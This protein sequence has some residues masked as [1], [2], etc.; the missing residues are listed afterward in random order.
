MITEENCGTEIDH[1][2]LAVGYGK[3][4]ENDYFLVKNSWGP[5]CGDNG[6]VKIGVAEGDGICG[7]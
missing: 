6:F 7:I 3:E 1:G 2:V 5:Q 4:G